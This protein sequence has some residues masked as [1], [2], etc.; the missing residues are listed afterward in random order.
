[1]ANLQLSIDVK[2]LERV[3]EALG[4]LSGLQAREAYAKALTDAGYQLRRAMQREI[5]SSFD[6]VTPFIRKAPKVFQ[7]TADKL[8]VAV[9]PTLHTERTFQRG[10]KV[11]VDPQQVLQAQE[12][13]GNRADKRSEVVLRSAGWLP[14]GFQTAIP[15]N[16]FP[17]SVDQYGNIRGTFIRSVLSFL[18]AFQSGQGSTQNMNKKARGNVKQ[19]G[20]GTIS[21]R[22]KEQAGPFM[23]RT[24]FVAGGRAAVTWDN[25]KYREGV[26]KTAHL[27][28]GIWASLGTGSR[29]QIRPVLIF[30]RRPTYQ[31]RLSMDRIATQ[32]DLQNYLDRRVRKWV[33]EA[34]GV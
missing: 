28:P 18:Q 19:F 9:A 13:G 6:R 8:S 7:A 16:P 33:R 22:A 1:M 12:F 11:G 5:D 15:K 2:N 4:K 24:Y 10:G 31:S 27:Q 25:R 20:R 3:S 26:N 23:G 14:P 30:V 17:G 32:A 34:A 29:R 21:K